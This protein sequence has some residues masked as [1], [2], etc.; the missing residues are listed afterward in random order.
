MAHIVTNK[1]A[2][3][4]S[5]RV[6]IAV[7]IAIIAVGIMCYSFGSKSKVATNTKNTT[8]ESNVVILDE[9]TSKG[10]LTS[11]DL[12]SSSISVSI[13]DNKKTTNIDTSST[14]SEELV[15]VSKEDIEP[16]KP[17][18][19]EEKVFNNKVEN[20]LESVSAPGA[21]FGLMPEPTGLSR[22][23]AIEYLRKPIE[24]LESDDPETIK[25][26][27]RTAA[28][29]TEAL[30]YIEHG[31]TFDQFIRDCVAY[32]NEASATIKE[33]RTEM[34]R[35]LY[36]KG[37]EAAQAYLDDVNPQLKEAGL[38]EVKIRKGDIIMTERK[39]AREQEKQNQ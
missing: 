27:E 23:E 20:L 1:A 3:K 5:T 34:R 29:K 9:L 33:V 7:I 26:K 21:N 36:D 6:H 32:A 35:L 16:V 17:I 12:G 30:E 38:E 10:E 39:K 11:K 24:I 37:V 13:N 25:L 4:S 19:V 31:G 8:A 22:E 15:E 2:P 18:I 28:M 14:S